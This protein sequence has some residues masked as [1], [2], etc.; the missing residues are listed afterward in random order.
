MAP[1]PPTDTLH[2]SPHFKALLV[3]HLIAEPTPR[4]PIPIL[5][6]QLCVTDVAV[7]LDLLRFRRVGGRGGFRGGVC[8]RGPDD[9]LQ[10]RGEECELVDVL[11]FGTEN[12]T[13]NLQIR[14]VGGM[15][16]AQGV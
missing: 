8:G 3:N 1:S 7:T 11:I 12:G 14:S 10:L 6:V 9:L 16:W 4:H 15:N 2:R 5:G 13:K